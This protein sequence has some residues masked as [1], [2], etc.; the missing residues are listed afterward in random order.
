M[1]YSLSF[2]Q[3][4][5]YYKRLLLSPLKLQSTHLQ[6]WRVWVVYTSSYVF[7][8]LK[9]KCGCGASNIHLVPRYT[10][11]ITELTSSCFWSDTFNM[12][13][14]M[15]LWCCYKVVVDRGHTVCYISWHNAETQILPKSLV[16][17]W[18]TKLIHTNS[19]SMWLRDDPLK[20]LWRTPSV[21]VVQTIRHVIYNIITM[22]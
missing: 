6:C 7:V 16:W 22:L 17:L 13:L 19:T 8:F 5:S 21:C 9:Q 4:A 11:C 12:L 14:W 1:N 18:S 20:I 3:T 15:R 10:L 2:C